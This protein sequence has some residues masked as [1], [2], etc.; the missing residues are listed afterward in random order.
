MEVKLNTLFNIDGSK[1]PRKRVGRGIGSGTGKTCGAG[2]KGQKSRSGVAIKTEGGQ[3]P[4]IKRLP[5][6]GFSCSKSVQYTAI[7]ISDIEMLIDLKRIDVTNN[8][9]KELLVS[10]GYIKSNKV[11]VKLLGGAEKTK[12]KLTIELDACSA[13]AKAVIESA[14]GKVL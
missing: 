7:S 9:N 11:P 2:H 13:S 3:N 10:I 1:K 4:L 6:R 5:K 8:V 14:G 12:H